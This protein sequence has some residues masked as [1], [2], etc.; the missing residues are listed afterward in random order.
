MANVPT[1]YTV[2]KC[3]EDFNHVETYYVQYERGKFYCS[4]P[5]IHAPECRHIKMVP[6]F[7]KH[8]AVGKGKFYCYDTEE[9]RMVKEF[10]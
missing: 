8:R 1:G 9:W 2:T 5:N 7:N 10:E 3:D 4:C 6:I